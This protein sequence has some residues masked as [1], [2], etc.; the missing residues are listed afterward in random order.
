MQQKNEAQQYCNYFSHS[1]MQSGEWFHLNTQLV[2]NI[3]KIATIDSRT[4]QHKDPIEM[5]AHIAIDCLSVKSAKEI[6]SAYLLFSVP[7]EHQ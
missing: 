3:Y 2:L 1:C 7:E 4:E 5:S 6:N